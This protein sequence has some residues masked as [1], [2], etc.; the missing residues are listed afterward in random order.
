MAGILLGT[1]GDQKND[2]LNE[3]T[4]EAVGEKCTVLTD[5]KLTNLIWVYEDTLTIVDGSGSGGGGVSGTLVTG[6]GAMWQQILRLHRTRQHAFQFERSILARIRFA[7]T[8]D[9]V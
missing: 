5:E 7:V 4:A 9:A 6:S 3:A 8:A 1:G 2:K